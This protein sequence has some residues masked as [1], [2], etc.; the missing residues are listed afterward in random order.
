VQTSETRR[1]SARD[2]LLDVQKAKV[3]CAKSRARFFCQWAGLGRFEPVTIHYFPFSF[4]ARLREFIGNSRKMIKI[5][6]QF[7]YTP[8][9]L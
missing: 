4:S 3:L 2:S 5:W 6:D 7:Y 1:N 8:K 9:F